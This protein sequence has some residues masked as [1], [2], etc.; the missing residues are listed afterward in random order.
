MQLTPTPTAGYSPIQNTAIVAYN[1][2][3]R[4]QALTNWIA[5][6]GAESGYD[7]TNVSSSGDYG[8]WQVNANAHA[9]G[10]VATSSWVQQAFTPATNASWAY[11]ISGGGK[12][13]CP[14]Y[15]TSGVGCAD[16]AAYNNA[17]NAHL[18]A[19]QQAATWVTN[20]AS[21]GALPQPTW[22]ANVSNAPSSGTT[23]TLAVA[24]GPGPAQSCPQYSAWAS[25]GDLISGG[26]LNPGMFPHSNQKAV[27]SACCLVSGAVI[28]VA[29]LGV[30]VIALGLGRDKSGAGAIAAT[31]ARKTPGVGTAIKVL[32]SSRSRPKPQ[33]EPEAA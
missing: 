20:L 22:G 32:G 29:G 21:K 31:V 25:S 18:P 8:L 1:A 13:M 2:G 23:A 24:W 30:L 9:P 4:G 10:G 3:F 14:W 16:P 33:A 6:A 17:Y 7:P 26:F 11:A 12:N 5:I 28:C 27:V 19:A 15:T